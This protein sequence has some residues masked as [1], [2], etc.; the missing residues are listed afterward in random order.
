MKKKVFSVLL[1]AL[2]ILGSNEIMA[3]PIIQRSVDGCKEEKCSKTE[4]V[5]CHDKSIDGKVT[6]GWCINCSGKGSNSCPRTIAGS[7]LTSDI[8]AVD[9]IQGQN[10][11]DHALLRISEGEL[12]G[13]H[14]ITINDN[15]KTRIYVVN[16]T[17]DAN[18]ESSKIVIDR[19]EK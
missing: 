14:E 5:L 3:I 18:Q 1:S 9:L 4:K 8:D 19:S 7:P 13:S 10:L 15:G 2:S 12:N 16:W 6:D 17:S 11:L